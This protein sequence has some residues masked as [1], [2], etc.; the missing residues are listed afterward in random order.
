MPGDGYFKSLSELKGV[1]AQSEKQQ[2]EAISFKSY[3]AAMNYN[4]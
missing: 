4:W 1:R 2:L 3:P